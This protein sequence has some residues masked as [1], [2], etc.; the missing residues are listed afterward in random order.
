MT[1]KGEFDGKV[2]LVTGAAMGI[3]GAV[4]ELL[5]ARGASLVLVD[6]DAKALAAMAERTGGEAVAGN[7]ADRA[8]L[9]AAIDRVRSRFGRLDV[10]SNNAGIQRYGTLE[11]TTEAIWDEVFDINLKA[12]FRLSALAIPLLRESRGAIVNMASVQG[13]ASQANVVAY[14][15][16]KHA[17]IGLTRAAAV[18]HAP[19][20]IRVNAVAPGSVD[21]PMLRATIAMADDPAALNAAIDGMHPLGRR[22][23]ASEIAEVV[24]FLASDRA[25]FVTGAVYVADGGLTIPLGGAPKPAETSRG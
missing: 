15:A 18:D 24:A 19:E 23:A 13:L 2:A 4:A 7:I 16:A 5:A 14:T 8:T 21:T 17:L 3:G 25:S 10:L 12:I 20:G 9:E 1:T 22:A 6:R 11:T